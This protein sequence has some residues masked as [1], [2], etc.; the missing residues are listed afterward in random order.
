LLTLEGQEWRER[1]QKM[2]PIFTSGKI[3]M[4]FDI[5][6]LIGERLISAMSLSLET[7]NVQDMKSFSARY[8]G[9]VIGNAVFG[10]ECRFKKAQIKFL[11]Y[12]ST[13][14]FLLN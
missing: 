1:R 11:R 12:F 5:V 13:K 9:D 4:M 8:T 14:H 10:L 6:N 3:K 7:S 2:S